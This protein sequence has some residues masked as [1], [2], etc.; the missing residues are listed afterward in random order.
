MCWSSRNK[1]AAAKL[2][3]KLLKKY[4]FVPDRLITD[5]LRSYGAAARDLGIEKHHERGRGRTIERRTH[6]SQSD[7]ECARCKV[8][9]A[10]D[11]PNDFSQ[12]MQPS[13]TL[14]RPTSSDICVD[15]PRL[16]SRGD[17]HL[18]RGG[19]LRTSDTQPFC[20]T[21]LAT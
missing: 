6:I 21:R 7:D 10:E 11:Q 13:T 19:R 16:P 15:A 4:G 20:V 9:R 17:G 1:H 12:P 3:R 18:A 14:Q 8:S 2:M 5:D